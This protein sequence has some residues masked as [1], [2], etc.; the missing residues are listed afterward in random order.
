L[1]AADC[2]LRI[3]RFPNAL[4][5]FLIRGYFILIKRLTI[6]PV[7]NKKFIGFPP[8]LLVD[9]P[10]RI[11]VIDEVGDWIA[12]DKPA[13]IPIR[14][15][16]WNRDMAD[17]DAA[18]NKQLQA[19]KS[20]LLEGGATLFGS[21]YNMEPE[22]SGIALFAKNRDSLDRLRNLAGSEKL[23]Y[24]FLLITKSGAA[25]AVD[26]LIAD[27]PLLV[28]NTKPKMIPSTAKGKK[29]RT[30]FRRICESPLGWALWEASTLFPR[31]HQVRSHAAVEGIA[32][33]GDSLY[34]GPDVPLL[35]ELMPR[36]RKTAISHP[37]FDGIALHLS[38]VLLPSPEDNSGAIQLSA[39]LPKRFQLLLQRLQ[40]EYS[41]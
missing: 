36:R 26:E 38:E 17:M 18:L 29:A 35:S 32:V 39:A 8:G 1:C 33:L 16:P 9:S 6:N 3:Y 19:K 34:S 15:H 40:L 13:G 22:I 27:A 14:Q 11:P 7:S 4:D 23:Q 2:S 41:K 37:V 30:H 20:E 10:L 12:V 25:G 5:S 24:K 21:V 31:L 28:H